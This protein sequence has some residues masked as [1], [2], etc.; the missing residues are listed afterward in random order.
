MCVIHAFS[1]IFE[2]SPANWRG[3]DISTTLG[4]VPFYNL[5]RLTSHMW[6]SI[7]RRSRTFYKTQ[8][9]ISSF[10]GL[11]FCQLLGHYELFTAL[12]YSLSKRVQELKN[13]SQVD[14]EMR[15]LLSGRVS[16]P[17]LS[18]VTSIFFF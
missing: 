11:L 4:Y 8:R 7:C 12:K 15:D 6:L 18:K 5:V 1:P 14:G 17:F 2:Q 3:H 13:L 16:D 9:P 10:S